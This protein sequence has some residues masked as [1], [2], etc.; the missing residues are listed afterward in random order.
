MKRYFSLTHKAYNSTGGNEASMGNTGTG[1]GYKYVVS[2][3]AIN[4]GDVVGDCLAHSVRSS[5]EKLNLDEMLFPEEL[6]LSFPGESQNGDVALF[7][8]AYVFSIMLLRSP[9][10]RLVDLC[11]SCWL[12]SKEESLNARFDLSSATKTL[13]TFVENVLS[14]LCLVSG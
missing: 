7:F 6:P 13:Q 11:E 9:S 12:T 14:G 3:V 8:I 4:T 1:D 5:S 10:E 2:L